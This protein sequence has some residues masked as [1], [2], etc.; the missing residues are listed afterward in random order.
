MHRSEACVYICHENGIHEFV[1]Y[2]SSHAAVD[3]WISLMD[4]IRFSCGD[5]IRYLYD[6]RISGPLPIYYALKRNFEA[7]K[8]HHARHNIRT[9]NAQVCRTPDT[10]AA[11]AANII[12]VFKPSH[13]QWQ[14]FN[15]D[16]PAAVNWLL[17]STSESVKEDP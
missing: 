15:E 3:Q 6:T 4:S 11:F 16:H 17:N 12:R 5:T 13:A 14:L 7:Q 10:Y 1:F 8:R 2:Q 9:F